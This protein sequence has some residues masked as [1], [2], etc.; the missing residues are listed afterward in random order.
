MAVAGDRGDIFYEKNCICLFRDFAFFNILTV[1][2]IVRNKLLLEIYEQ[3]YWYDIDKTRDIV[4]NEETARRIAEAVID[5]DELWSWNADED[6][7]MEISFDEQNYLWKVT[8][9]PKIP[10][11]YILLDGEKA[12][13]IRRDTGWIEIYR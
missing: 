6:Y 9:H 5:A 8:Y 2:Y 13:W 11:G 12:V 1:G 4:P 10:E 7:E 3:A